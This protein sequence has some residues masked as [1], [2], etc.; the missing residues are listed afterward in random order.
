MVE[1]DDVSLDSWVVA[2]GRPGDPGAPLN[3]PVVAASNYV[4][5]GTHEYSRDAQGTPTVNALETL[6]GGMEGG[7]CVAFSSGM[8]AVAAMFDGLPVGAD[9]AIPDDC[10]QGA[11]AIADDGAKRGRWSVQRIAL[12]DT[13][14]WIEAVG[15]CDL[16]WLESPSNPLLGVAD[17]SAI[18]AAP[19]SDGCLVGVDNTFATP[20]N[21]RPLDF[22]ADV[23]MH[24]VTKFIGGHSD[25]LAGALVTNDAAVLAQLQ[26]SRTVTGALPGALECFLAT[27]GART[28]GVR[29][30]RSQATALVLAQRLEESERVDVVRYPGLPSHPD[31]AVAARVLE[32]FGAMV[33]FDVAGTAAEADAV[34]ARLRLITHATSLG[35]VESTI[36]RRAVLQGQEHLPPTLLRLSVGCEDVEDLWS[37]LAQALAG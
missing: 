11:A 16:V 35:G 8:A 23:V 13:G 7:A 32:G 29:L 20:F 26:R 9:V 31:H 27:R 14:G 15:R 17:L 34:L 6:V 36:E 5:G 28:M 4:L 19:R 10:Y 18:C 24:S 2:G 30:E 22:G 25:L 3:E 12:S 33:S 1:R 37:D 21:Q